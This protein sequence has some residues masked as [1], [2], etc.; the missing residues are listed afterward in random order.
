MKE[1]CVET[2]FVLCRMKIAN[3]Q[4]LYKKNSD[5]NTSTDKLE[6]FENK[7]KKPQT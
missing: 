7:Q 5:K 4:S 3:H 1:K 6:K 2:F